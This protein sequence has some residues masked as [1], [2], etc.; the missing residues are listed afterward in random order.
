VKIVHASLACALLLHAGCDEQWN[1]SGKMPAL[2]GGNSDDA[3]DDDADSDPQHD[4]DGD[5]DDD[6]PPID[7]QDMIDAYVYSLGTPWLEPAE[8]HAGEPGPMKPAGDYTCSETNF[9]ETKQYDK[10]IAFAAN[11]HTLFPGAV[12]GGNSIQTG[13]FVPKVLPRAPIDISASLEGVVDGP[14]SATLD[15]PTM[16]AYRD[17]MAQILDAPL[18]GNTPAAITF[19]IEEVYS[20]EQFGLAVGLGVEWMTGEISASFGWEEQDTKSRFG[21]NFMQ[22]YYTVDMDVPSTPSDFFADD[23]TLDDVKQVLG[24]DPP[25]YVASVSYGRMVYFTVNSSFSSEEV[26]AALEWGFEAGWVDIEGSVSLTHSEILAESQI[27]A[28]VL[29]GN[30]DLAVHTINGA[31]GLREFILSGG[32]F[33]HQSLGAPIA[34]KL[35]YMA[36]NTPARF[37]LTTDYTYTECERISQKIRVALKRIEVSSS[38]EDSSA[39]ELYGQV[40]V[41]D[42]DNTLWPLFDRGS[43]Q[44]VHIFAGDSWP[45]GGA[46]EIASWIIPMV[47]QPNHSFALVLNLWEKDDGSDDPLYVGSLLRPFE[48]GWRASEWSVPFAQAHQ[49]GNLVFELMPVP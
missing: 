11:S 33:S 28:F 5:P 43:G 47:P 12:V 32:S 23:V 7:E 6:A 49:K 24:H 48:D 38:Y 41:Q 18:I 39:L 25:A 44:A 34:Y 22:T 21:I 14:I 37:S 16:S 26:R 29:G 2:G 30:G 45:Q 35:H 19:D 36:D 40:D 4:D 15:E 31:E 27:T 17:A 42:E 1:R 10:V 8:E 9:F 3:S 13:L 46:S 20:E